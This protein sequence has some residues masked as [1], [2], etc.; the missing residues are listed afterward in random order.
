M[1]KRVEI[2]HFFMIKSDAEKLLSL[3][4][5]RRI[6]QNLVSIYWSSPCDHED[7]ELG[8]IDE[9]DLDWTMLLLTTTKEMFPHVSIQ[10]LSGH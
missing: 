9:T 5:Q 6:L 2:S 8:D 1:L 3:V 7:E 10:E 4:R